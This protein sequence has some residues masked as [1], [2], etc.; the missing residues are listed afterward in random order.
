MKNKALE[1]KI[2]PMIEEK[3]FEHQDLESLHKKQQESLRLFIPKKKAT[4]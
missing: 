4:S 2:S 1:E 3:K